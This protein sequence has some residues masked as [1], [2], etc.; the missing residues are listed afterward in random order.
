MKL[1]RWFCRWRADAHESDAGIYL[2]A[3]MEAGVKGDGHGARFL[4]QLAREALDRRNRWRRRAG[5]KPPARG[6]PD[7]QWACVR[8]R[9]PIGEPCYCSA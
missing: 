3:A 5:I 9:A 2:L 6:E 1:W 7:A 4:Q 8:C